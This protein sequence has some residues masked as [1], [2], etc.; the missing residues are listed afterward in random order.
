MTRHV[1]DRAV[2]RRDAAVRRLRRAKQALT[3]LSL[4]LAGIVGTA[5][6]RAF[7]GR[8]SHHTATVT[9]PVRYATAR[10]G[11][12]ASRQV[13][14]IRTHPRHHRARS[15]R[16]GRAANPGTTTAPGTTTTTT[17]TTQSSTTPAPTPQ[18][19]SSPAPPATTPAP[20]PSTS[21]AVTSGGS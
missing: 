17:T 20:A 3:V 21:A 14:G 18:T 7:P 6:A 4:L 10:H 12:P 5:A 11:H 16:T 15:V 9:D 1:R 19:T 13:A 8:S 2:R